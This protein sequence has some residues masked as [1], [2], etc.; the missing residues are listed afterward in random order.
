[1]SS[2]NVNRTVELHAPRAQETPSGGARRLVA[3]LVVNLALVLVAE[4]AVRTLAWDRLWALVAAF[5]VGYLLRA[6]VL[7]WRHRRA[8]APAPQPS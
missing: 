7:A 2:A 4:L 8:Q 3:D 6:G 5:G 1:M